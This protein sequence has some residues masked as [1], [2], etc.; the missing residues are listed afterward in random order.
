MNVETESCRQSRHPPSAHCGACPVPPEVHS[1]RPGCLGRIGQ[2]MSGANISFNP[3]RSNHSSPATY[4]LDRWPGWN[5][6]AAR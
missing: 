4:A 5:V 1:E 2:A 6:C 3:L